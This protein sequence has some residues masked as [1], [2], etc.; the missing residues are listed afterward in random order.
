MVRIA[1]LKPTRVVLWLD[2]DK[3][4]DAREYAYKFNML[5]PFCRALSTTKD[6]KC[7]DDED[8]KRLVG[9]VDVYGD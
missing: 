6:P 2:F 5:Y 1:K 7:F 3:A 8:I 4:L 9:V